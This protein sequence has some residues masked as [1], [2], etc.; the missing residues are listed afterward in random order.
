MKRSAGLTRTTPLK[1][2]KL[3]RRRAIKRRPPRA[4]SAAERQ[5]AAQW[6]AIVR[7]AGCCAV[8]GATEDDRDEHGQRKLIVLQGHHVISQ[9][10]L[11]QLERRLNLDAG[12]LVW[13]RS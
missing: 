12:S 1:R 10:V 6:I 3:P 13:E 5:L 9:S 7:K 8:C 2:S 11:R 4:L